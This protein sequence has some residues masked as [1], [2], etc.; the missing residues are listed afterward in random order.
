LFLILYNISG[1]RRECLLV[2]IGLIFLIIHPLIT[3][4][5]V[6]AYLFLLTS[7]SLLNLQAPHSVRFLRHVFAEQAIET[8]SYS[9][10]KGRQQLTDNHIRDADLL[11]TAR[12]DFCVNIAV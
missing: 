12:L 9:S 2:H 10:I 5:S 6:I 3:E 8:G 11:K 1:K 4:A 7:A